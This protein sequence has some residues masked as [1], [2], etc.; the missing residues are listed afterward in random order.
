M[1]PVG[2]KFLGHPGNHLNLI[3]EIMRNRNLKY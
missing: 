1:L 2:E 3:V